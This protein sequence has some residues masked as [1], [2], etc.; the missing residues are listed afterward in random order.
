MNV[1][2][3]EFNKDKAK[4]AVAVADTLRTIEA[5]K[6]G[7]LVVVGKD[8]EADKHFFNLG[9]APPLELIAELRIM[10]HILEHQAISQ[11][12]LSELGE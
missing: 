10:L 12:Q 1:I 6:W 2:K 5:A 8:S 7:W 11:T 3:L 4:L 9:V